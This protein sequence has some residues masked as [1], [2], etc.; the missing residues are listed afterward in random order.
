MDI[1][2][3][4]AMSEPVPLDKVYGKYLSEKD[5]LCLDISYSEFINALRD[6]E[7]RGV[8]KFLKRNNE[9]HIAL[10]EDAK[11]FLITYSPA[12]VGL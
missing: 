12:W 8:I 1:I 7:R 4:L 5:R 10:T 6:L 11:Y 9:T 2:G 3:P